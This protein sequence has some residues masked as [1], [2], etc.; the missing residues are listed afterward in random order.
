MPVPGGDERP[1]L[2]ESWINQPHTRVLLS[3][4][5]TGV[6]GAACASD[7]AIGLCRKATLMASLLAPIGSSSQFQ[8]T[9][10]GIFGM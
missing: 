6:S 2:G 3:R 5:E 1:A 10:E 8:I 9:S 4:S 7:A